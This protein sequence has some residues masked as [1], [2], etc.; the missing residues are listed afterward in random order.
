MSGC[1]TIILTQESLLFANIQVQGDR[2]R[3]VDPQ[4]KGTHVDPKGKGDIC[5]PTGKRGM[6]I[7]CE[8]GMCRNKGERI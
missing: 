8:C 5:R 3:Y 4:E 1:L 7:Q 6:E 2:G